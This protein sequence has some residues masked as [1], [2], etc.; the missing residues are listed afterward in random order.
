LRQIIRADEA[1]MPRSDDNAIVHL[2][3]LSVCDVNR[4]MAKAVEKITIFR[5][6][7]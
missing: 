2:D 6:S 3:D 1:V 5:R 7:T 4:W